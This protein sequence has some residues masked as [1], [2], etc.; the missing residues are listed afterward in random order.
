MTYINASKICF[1]GSVMIILL[2]PKI[3]KNIPAFQELVK[4]NNLP[5]IPLPT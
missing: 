5:E 3:F 4:P 1:R 2:A